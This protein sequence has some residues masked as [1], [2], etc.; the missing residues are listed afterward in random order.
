MNVDRILRTKGYQ[1]VSVEPTE[2]VAE[3]AAVLNRHRIGAALVRNADGAVIGVF[4]ERDVVKGISRHGEAC[5]R[6][7]VKELM[8]KD[9]ITCTPEDTVDHVMAVMTERR[10]RHLPVMRHG[11]LVGVISIGDVVKHRLAE[12]E[13]EAKALRDYIAMG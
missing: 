2:S 1:V 11:N 10:V 8:A 9:V 4:S 5:L 12:I 6:L 3:A 7:S 13:T